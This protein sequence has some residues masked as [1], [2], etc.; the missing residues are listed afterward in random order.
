VLPLM[1][2]VSVVAM[3]D[4]LTWA[5]RDAD[6]AAV[7]PR[8]GREWCDDE[9]VAVEVGERGWM[10]GWG[11]GRGRGAALAVAGKK[12]GAFA[13]GAPPAAAATALDTALVNTPAPPNRG[14]RGTWGVQA[15]ADAVPTDAGAPLGEWVR[16]AA[17]AAVNLPGRGTMGCWP[18]SSATTLVEAAPGSGREGAA[19]EVCGSK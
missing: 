15:D 9:R 17:T 16:V 7:N 18:V 10:D 13:V 5:A 4:A 14:T 8:E 12:G 6:T 1:L 11:R 2:C 19:E 3:P